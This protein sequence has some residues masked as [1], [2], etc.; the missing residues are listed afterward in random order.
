MYLNRFNYLLCFKR[1]FLY[2][3]LVRLTEDDN[4]DGMPLFLILYEL[5]TVVYFHM[6]NTFYYRSLSERFASSI[7]TENILNDC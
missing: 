2:T 6:Q 5:R 1:D 3:L 4:D 7:R